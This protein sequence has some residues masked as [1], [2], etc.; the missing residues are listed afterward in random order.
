MA[1]SVTGPVFTPG[2]GVDGDRRLNEDERRIIAR[3]PSRL[4]TLIAGALEAAVGESDHWLRGQRLE[5]PGNREGLGRPSRPVKEP[6]EAFSDGL[7]RESCA[8]P[9]AR[10]SGFPGRPSPRGHALRPDRGGC[11]APEGRI[12]FSAPP[13]RIRTGRAP[14]CRDRHTGHGH[15]RTPPRTRHPGSRA[16]GTCR[17]ARAI[18][19]GGCL[20][21]R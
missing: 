7:H 9:L 4:S 13:G 10:S 2:V 14:D 20:S 17:A 5:R 16:P 11:N 18:A 6:G 1:R 8:A 19:G 15:S 21:I 12:R 3:F